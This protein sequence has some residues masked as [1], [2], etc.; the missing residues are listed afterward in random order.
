MIV[1]EKEMYQAGATVRIYTK[2][3]KWI[4]IGCV[5]PLFWNDKRG[6]DDMKL[7]VDNRLQQR[8][9]FTSDDASEYFKALRELRM[10]YDAMVYR[11]V[12]KPVKAMHEW[13]DEVEF[14]HEIK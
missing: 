2:E 11:L 8:L 10:L 3:N 14:R 6:I 4:N 13:C 12:G 5:S 7:Y 9:I 1:V